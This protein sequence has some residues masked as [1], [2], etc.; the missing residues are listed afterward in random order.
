MIV[1]AD[2]D[3]G[4]CRVVMTQGGGKRWGGPLSRKDLRAETG[5]LPAVDI[6][7]NDDP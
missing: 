2:R 5:T 6:L 1:E 4:R 7:S 3:F